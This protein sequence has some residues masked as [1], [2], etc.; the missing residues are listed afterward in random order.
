MLV[1]NQNTWLIC[2]TANIRIDAVYSQLTI[3]FYWGATILEQ[4]NEETGARAAWTVRNPYLSGVSLTLIGIIALWIIANL[5]SPTSFNDVF[6][7]LIVIPIL[8]LLPGV[9]LAASLLCISLLKLSLVR[10]YNWTVAITNTLALILN[11]S[12]IIFFIKTVPVLF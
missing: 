9:S 5:R 2:Y 8:I 11:V 3:H 10:P 12:A 1:R 6:T 4:Q 7:F